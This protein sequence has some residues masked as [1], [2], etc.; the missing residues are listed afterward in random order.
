MDSAHDIVEELR[1]PTSALRRGIPD[2]WE[3]FGLLHD[4][5]M[6]DGALAGK[7]KQLIALAISVV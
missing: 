2:V 7:Q 4:A 5:A 6:A 3:G 1:D